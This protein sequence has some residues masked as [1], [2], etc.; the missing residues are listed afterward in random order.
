MPSPARRA[1][2][3]LTAAITMALAAGAPAM[4]AS[5]VPVT[6]RVT[7]GANDPVAGAT[8]VARDALTGQVVS[9]SARS[10]HLG[11]AT[12][13]V[14]SPPGRRVTIWAEGGRSR[15]GAPD[16]LRATV[17]PER[18]GTEFAYVN[19][20]STVISHYAAS[21]PRMP[22]AAVATRVAKGL[23]MPDPSIDHPSHNAS[24]TAVWFSGRRFHEIARDRGGEHAHA[25]RI[26][27]NITARRRVSPLRGTRGE[28]RLPGPPRGGARE[29]AAP[30]PPDPPTP[31]VEEIAEEAAEEGESMLVTGGKWLAG[32]AISWAWD[33]YGPQLGLKYSV[34]L[35]IAKLRKE[36]I[37]QFQ[38]IHNQINQLQ[39]GIAQTLASQKRVEDALAKMRSDAALARYSVEYD[40]LQA[41]V[42]TLS[43]LS[44]RTAQYY[45][46]HTDPAPPDSPEGKAAAQGV[47]TLRNNLAQLIKDDPCPDIDALVGVIPPSATG[48]TSLCMGIN[49]QGLVQIAQGDA[50]NNQF[51]SAADQFHV[52]DA[53]GLR[54]LAI[55][56]QDVA[57]HVL[58]WK[59]AADA[60]TPVLTSEVIDATGK[61]LTDGLAAVAAD[62]TGAYFGVRIPRSHVVGVSGLT[63]TVYGIGAFSGTGGAFTA[64][65]PV[66]GEGEVLVGQGDYARVGTVASA[67]RPAL[68]AAA[69]CEF[70]RPAASASSELTAAWNGCRLKTTP[71]T[72][73]G[74]PRPWRIADSKMPDPI[75]R[76]DL[77]DLQVALASG[78]S[79]FTLETG[80][81]GTTPTD[82]PDNKP[83]AARAALRGHRCD[84]F[85]T[86]DASTGA[87]C[88]ITD[89]D[90]GPS[91][92]VVMML[93]GPTS[94][95]MPNATD[96]GL[97]KQA[98][99][100]AGPA[101]D[102]WGKGSAF[103]NLCPT[104][105]GPSSWY[106]QSD[107]FLAAGKPF[108]DGVWGRMLH[109]WQSHNRIAWDAPGP[110][111]G[112]KADHIQQCINALI[113]GPNWTVGD[114][115]S[116]AYVVG[117]LYQRGY[118]P[119]TYI[120]G[121]GP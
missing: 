28:S 2:V 56:W 3:L 70:L 99:I 110:A 115:T 113:G 1:L 8:V 101:Q 21:H 63:G 121:T 65:P 42:A 32:Q 58:A 59:S 47:A 29:N 23:R 20:V 108:P 97:T 57:M 24:Y 88:V 6:V 103:P 89:G 25:V 53:T 17:R 111:G 112:C 92:G 12:L 77:P 83:W 117:A 75:R 105:Y 4:A 9:N 54:W 10:G 46:D 119:N 40:R 76:V 35:D 118:T 94:N 16:I 33:T 41:A 96:V 30:P 50:A 73:V 120:P 95:P 100:A 51:V 55:G 116:G 107:L 64:A 60:A 69:Y 38:G 91:A 82:G 78:C 13:L 102:W 85:S 48:G 80:F 34:E 11:V 62:R 14:S 67:M 68:A 109:R 44:A 74:P 5:E 86:A 18:V 22:L 71:T 106:K 39:A 26:A 79:D 84:V 81:T 72:V 19:P 7:L 31:P 27:A 93:P 114:K 98:F 15:V 61:H 87:N 90:R 37:D 45:T 36:M 66:A 43:T 104:N 49:R 52:I